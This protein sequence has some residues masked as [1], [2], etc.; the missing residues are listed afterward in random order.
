MTTRT[1]SGQTTLPRDYFVSP[2]IFR[3]EQQTI[4]GERWLCIGRSE[5]IAE[6]GSYF[7]HEVDL[8]DSAE[9]VIVLRDHDGP[10]NGTV[11]A[12]YNVC[13]HRGTQ[14]CDTASGRFRKTIQCPYHAWTYTLE[15]ELIGAPNMQGDADFNKCDWALLSPTLVEWE[16]FL[17][18]N[19]SREPQPLAEAFA[20]L[21]GRFDAWHLADLRVAHRVEYD[22]AANWKIIAQNYS[23]CYHCPTV[24]PLLNELSPS[25]SFQM[26]LTEGPFLG[27]PMRLSNPNGS[28]T[29]SGERC[30]PPINGLAGDGL[31]G[32]GRQ[33]VYY[34]TGFPSFFLSLHPDYVMVHRLEPLAADRT[35]VVCEWLF[36]PDAMRQPDFAPDDAVGLLGHDQSPGLARLRTIAAGRLVAGLRAGAVRRAGEFARRV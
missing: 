3:R 9:S 28:M 10:E 18:L 19:L 34:V 23:E 20:P 22:V 7:L 17:L 16:G 4:F 32:D 6:P 35:R 13:R 8:G 15:G 11:R 5:R 31:A 12:H 36:H 30:A 25:Q 29:L 14:L 33:T 1:A 24:H 21:M 2:D 26:E 27:G